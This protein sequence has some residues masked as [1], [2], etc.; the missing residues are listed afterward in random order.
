M[1]LALPML[2]FL[3]L[4]FSSISQSIETR[5]E[6]STLTELTHLSVEYSELVHELQKER[7][8]T[9]GFIGSNGSK[10]SV[11]LRKQRA[12]TDAKQAK[13][14]RFWQQNE[15]SD[16]QIQQLHMRITQDLSMLTSIRNKVDAQNIELASALRYYTQLN[17]K[18]LSVSGLIVD[19][20]SDASITAETIAY[21]NFLQGKERA[22]IERAVLSNVFSKDHFATDNFVKFISLV[23]EQETYFLNFKT[24]ATS[25]NNN[26]FVQQLN[27]PAVKEVMKLRHIAETNSTEFNVDAEYWFSQASARI[28]QLKL[29]EDDLERSLLT[30]A[31]NHRNSAVTVLMMNVV[32]SVLIIVIVVV[33][34]F[35]TIRDLM[36]RVNELMDVMTEVRDN[37]DLTVQTKLAGESELG[38]IASALNLTLS[39]FAGAM[40]N[41]STS[42]I[43]LASAAEETAQTCDYSSKS[44]AEQQD[45]ISLIATAIEELSATVKEVDTQAVSGFEIVQQ[46]SLSI[47]GLACEID[48]LAQRITNLH[49][50]SNNITNMVDVIKS[51]ADQT[52]LLALNAAIEAARA[53]EQGRG[54]A[55][56]ADEVRTLAKRTQESTA[57]IESFISALQADADAAFNV[58]EVSQTK[59][60]EA[61]SNSQD[62]AK[63]L[64]DITASVN[65][66]FSMTEQI[67]TA[68]E[69]QSVVTQDVAKNIVDVK[70]KSMESA[71]GSAQIAMTAKEQ[72]QLATSLQDIAKVFKI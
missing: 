70:Q 37:N 5:K 16:N 42:S 47:E 54:F 57:E 25:S 49:T 58:I 48:S 45:G 38:Q 33:I 64:Q 67:A 9:A 19:I 17:A 24:F 52:N 1:L 40:D 56:V 14:M 62:V 46:S 15:F 6:M 12:D 29:I 63:T 35:I 50:S 36:S 43:T 11:K 41:I 4:S 26:F 44:L 34:S 51:V 2:G 61:V 31:D 23:V 55:V 20:S 66:I 71:T 8:M 10:F 28:G 21:Y 22:G 3:W 7:G 32:F 69:E 60:S 27:T 53:G 13:M 30:L 39:E 65:Q 18:L 68:I 72:A 59:A